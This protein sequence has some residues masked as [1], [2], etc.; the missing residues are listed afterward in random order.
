MTEAPLSWESYVAA[1]AQYRGGY[2]VRQASPAARG[3]LRLAYGVARL[4]ARF[5]VTPTAVTIAGLAL[6]AAVP[7]LAA[8]GAGWPAVAAVF[9]L[10]AALADRVDGALAVITSRVS[11]LGQLYDA[12]V[13]RLAEVCWLLA[14]WALG[15]PVWLL[16]VCGGAALSHEYVRARVATVVAPPG[17]R[18]SPD[19][20]VG[21]AGAMTVGE[22]S[23][24]LWAAVL[25]LL[26]AGV[27]GFLHSALAAGVVTIAAVIWAFLGV[28]GLAQLVVRVRKSLSQG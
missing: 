16:V 15:A 10:V 25:G 11:R 1:R 4:L 3:T 21:E 18:H 19:R 5:G 27:A 22:R 24:R 20:T 2:D 26:L 7:L 23:G 28:F 17:A 14:F 12:L 8:L 6:N 13:D 9:V